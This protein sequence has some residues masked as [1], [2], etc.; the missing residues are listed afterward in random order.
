M[1]KANTA[2]ISRVSR[3]FAPALLAATAAV[4][5]THGVAQAGPNCPEGQSKLS[6]EALDR[7]SEAALEQSV[8]AFPDRDATGRYV[9]GATR[10]ESGAMAQQ[11]IRDCGVEAQRRTVVVDLVLPA[12]LPD[13]TRTF[14]AVAVSD[15]S[16]VF[17]VWRASA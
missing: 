13:S 5:V 15:F 16:G 7:A 6:S 2:R 17:K 10:S 14:G 12:M 1:S 9:S 11:I 4:T 3:I 8:S